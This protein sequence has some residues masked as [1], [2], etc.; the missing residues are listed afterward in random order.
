MPPT[1]DFCMAGCFKSTGLD[2]CFWSE[3]AV[4]V[5][6]ALIL[7]DVAVHWSVLS[8]ACVGGQPYWLGQLRRDVPVLATASI[9]KESKFKSL[10]L[11]GGFGYNEPCQ[12]SLTH[13][14]TV[15]FPRDE[16][17]FFTRTSGRVCVAS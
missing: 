15:R 11:V 12:G 9:V 13:P 17:E 1:L 10:W 14:G 3:C 5:T 2:S 6:I 8:V 16:V 4:T 7:A